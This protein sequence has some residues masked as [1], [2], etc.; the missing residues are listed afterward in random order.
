MEI[1]QAIAM[2]DAGLHVLVHVCIING[3]KTG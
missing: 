2:M 1:A 3:K